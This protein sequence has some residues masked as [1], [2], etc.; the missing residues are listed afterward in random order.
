MKRT[1]AREMSCQHLVR[2]AQLKSFIAFNQAI[3]P[4]INLISQ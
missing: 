4:I 3:N 1:R 2:F